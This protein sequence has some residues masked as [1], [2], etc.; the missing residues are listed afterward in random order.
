M[1]SLIMALY[2]GAISLGNLITSAATRL[3]EGNGAPLLTPVQF[4]LFFTGMM[5]L[6]ACVFIFVALGFKTQTFIQES[7]SAPI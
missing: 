6:A 2:L 5:A 7:S 3:N 4:D 1:K